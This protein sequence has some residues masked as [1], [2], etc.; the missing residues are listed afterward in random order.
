MFQKVYILQNYKY[1]KNPV[2]ST[3]HTQ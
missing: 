1:S 3:T 2:A